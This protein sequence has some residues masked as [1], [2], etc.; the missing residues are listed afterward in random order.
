MQLFTLLVCYLCRTNF[1]RPA[2]LIFMLVVV[3]TAFGDDFDYGQGFA[4]EKSNGKL[5]SCDFLFYENLA[6]ICF[7]RAFKRLTQ[8]LLVF[9]LI[10][11][12]ARAA[13]ARLDY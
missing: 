5:T 1:F 3:H 8:L 11:T 4:A 13:G 7:G 10:E 6:V 9:Y 12:D 2:R